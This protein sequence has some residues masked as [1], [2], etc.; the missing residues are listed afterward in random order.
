MRQPC[1]G[2]RTPVP[3]CHLPGAL[4]QGVWLLSLSSP[5]PVESF[6]M[7][8]KWPV[9]LPRD[10]PG[11]LG[12]GR[13]WAWPA[14]GGQALPVLQQYFL[15]ASSKGDSYHRHFVS[16]PCGLLEPAE[17]EILPGGAYAPQPWFCH[18]A[19]Q[20]EP[21]S[22]QPSPHPTT[23]PLLLPRPHPI[24]PF[25][26]CTGTLNSGSRAPDFQTPS[27]SHRP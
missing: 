2:S 20:P 5:L 10:L 15:W 27:A 24:A 6:M 17:S 11:R 7:K 3:P 1:K 14:L 18:S 12:R 8:M 19:S 22:L 23:G 9:F 13:H 21:P 25:P 16:Q 26:H 4:G